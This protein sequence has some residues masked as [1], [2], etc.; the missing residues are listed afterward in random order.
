MQV[1][2]ILE[3][4]TAVAGKVRCCTKLLPRNFLESHSELRN[5]FLRERAAINSFRYWNF[6]RRPE[7]DSMYMPLLTKVE[8][9]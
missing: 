8:R 7:D 6:Q 9:K 5:I 2:V 3:F 4:W 1:Q